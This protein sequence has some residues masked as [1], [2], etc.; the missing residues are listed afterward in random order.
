MGAVSACDDSTDAP[1][2]S[3]TA[4]PDADGGSPSTDSGLT[5]DASLESGALH[6]ASGADAAS[7]TSDGGDGRDGEAGAEVTYGTEAAPWAADDPINTRFTGTPGPSAGFDGSKFYANDL[8]DPWAIPLYYEREYTN[9]S[10]AVMH[11]VTCTTDRGFGTSV[12]FW[13]PKDFHGQVGSGGYSDGE[14]SVFRTDGS[15]VSFYGLGGHGGGSTALPT[16]CEFFQ[17]A[18]IDQSGMKKNTNQWGTGYSG[19]RAPQWSP[20]LGIIDGYFMSA[21]KPFRGLVFVVEAATNTPNDCGHA[22]FNYA[23]NFD[24]SGSGTGICEGQHFVIPA[25]TPKPSNL[26]PEGSYLWDVLVEFGAYDA[27]SGSNQFAVARPSPSG[28]SVPQMTQAQ[29]DNIN[30]DIATLFDNLH[31][32]ND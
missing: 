20:S 11:T 3:S 1:S 13:V 18:K 23:S 17:I 10:N 31:F 29:V 22:T 12:S 30:K 8:I 21:T 9:Q 32:A 19:S 24:G 4:S 2:G 28:S 25:S 5:A 27:D 15:I 7:S 16:S 14:A 26:T 6:D